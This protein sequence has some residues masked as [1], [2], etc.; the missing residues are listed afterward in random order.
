MKPE[1]PP[2]AL[3][4]ADALKAWS[5]A[6]LVA[7]VEAAE[8]PFTAEVRDRHRREWLFRIAASRLGRDGGSLQSHEPRLQTLEHAWYELFAQFS[9]KV[10]TGEITLWGRMTKP[11]VRRDAEPLPADRADE[12][13]YY[14]E[15]NIVVFREDAYQGVTAE[16]R[17]SGG[18]CAERLRGLRM[19]R[20][21]IPLLT[22]L[23]EWTDPVLISQVCRY[24]RDHTEYEMAGLAMHPMLSDAQDLAKPSDRRWMRGSPDF[25]QL[26]AAWD[27]VEDDFRARLVRGEFHLKGVMTQPRREQVASVIPGVWAA[28][29]RFEFQRNVV[30]VD[31]ARYVA[32]TASY[33]LASADIPPASIAEPANAVGQAAEAP[34]EVTAE[35]V[36]E[37][38][39]EE[40]LVLLDEYAR[41]VAEVEKSNLK[42]PVKVS[43]IPIL[44]RKLQRRFELGENAPTLGAEAAALESWIKG[45]VDGHQTP[46]AGHI[47]NE[48]REDHRRLRAQHPRPGSK[49]R[50]S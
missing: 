21:E 20:G 28:D 48:L 24:E 22:A 2:E 50:E 35:N 12:F 40:V 18:S 4:L 33:G 23:R 26:F 47:E 27:A 3:P 11:I 36:G 32:I 8:E 31:A 7:A 38:S 34:R 41:R 19:A 30:E 1:S 43:F 16:Q 39:D 6:A 25:T 37:L 17:S 46:T 14:P 5:A 45:K 13:L 49:D 42:L 10:A 9:S 44:R 15:R 29:L